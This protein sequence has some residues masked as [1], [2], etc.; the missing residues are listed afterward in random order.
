[1]LNDKEINLLRE[2]LASAENPLFIFDDDGDGFCS[3]LLLYRMH[4]KGKGF[5]L[6]TSPKLDMRLAVKVQE[7]NP[8]KIFVLD[9]PI[10][11]QEFVEQV[12]KPIFWIDHHQ[13]APVQG[14]YYFN[15]RSKEN[16]AYVPTT[17]MAYQVSGNEEDVWIAM[18][19]CLA[20]WYLPDFTDKFIEKYP[21]WLT[22]KKDL[23]DALYKQPAGLLVK[24]FFFLL[25][26]PSNDVHKAIKI[27]TRIISPAEIFKQ[28]SAQGKFL[29]KRFTDVN[30]RYESLLKEAKKT[31]TR[32]RIVLFYYTENQWSFTANLA[33]ELTALYQDKVIIIA[34]RKS[35][36]YKCSLR[37]Q[38]P[39]LKE[40]QAS[41]V[42]VNG[43]GGGHENACGAV[44]KEEDWDRFLE[45][46]K[47]QIKELSFD[48]GK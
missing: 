7:Y 28:E 16:N 18:A 40:V 12:K 8:D 37:A 17:R 23:V 29:F 4:H 25:K 36:E 32:R 26:G 6:K 41:L 21:E 46:F 31:V 47:E 30:R 3:F 33:N 44:I 10:I 13:P 11:D 45:M 20:D 14:V 1:M 38:V 15:P 35:G 24:M 19:G 34:R 27:L 2:E 22:E 9:V 48:K 39:I 5:V 42:G 43:Y